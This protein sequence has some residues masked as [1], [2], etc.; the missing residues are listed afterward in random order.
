MTKI[1]IISSNIHKTLAP[2]QLANCLELVKQTPHDYQVELLN[3]GIYE[4]PYVINAWHQKSPFDA[5][6]ALG[7]VLKTNQD[8][9]DYIMSH[10]RNCLTHFA[11]N[12]IAV[13]NGIISGVSSDDL[14]DK[15]DNPDPCV[16]AYP[17]AINAVNCLIALKNN[18]NHK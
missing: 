8:H 14:A 15:I 3:S 16:S 11:L 17:A 9:F 2:R 6:I 4:I 7:L 13:G 18:L 12:N 1:L 10:V 5:Y